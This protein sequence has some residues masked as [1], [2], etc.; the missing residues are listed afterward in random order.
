MSGINHTHEELTESGGLRPNPHSEIAPLGSI[1]RDTDNAKHHDAKQVRLIAASM[2]RFGFL[3]P[4]VV[5][6]NEMIVAG[7]GRYLAAKLLGLKQVPV[8]RARFLTEEDRTAYALADNKLAELSPWK[9]DVLAKQ[10][11]DL[12]AKNYDLGVTGFTLGDIDFSIPGEKTADEIEVVELPDANAKPVS[13]IGD[14]WLAGEHRLFNGDSQRPES[15][16]YAL[17]GDLARLICSDPPYGVKVRHNVS[18]KATAREFVMMSGE[19]T[20]PELI[21]FFRAVF[22]NCA[23]FSHEASIHYHFIDW[24]NLRHML[25]AADGVY[26]EFKQLLV[27]VKR[28][29]AL[30]AFYRSRHELVCVFKSG[31]GRHVNNFKMGET[32]RYRTNVLEHAGCSTFSKTRQRDL[33]DHPSIKPT[34]MIAEL[35]LDCSNS[36]D[37]VLDP[38]CGSGTILLAASKVGRR[39]VGI[40]LD[41][42]YV[43]TALRRLRDATGLVATLAGDGRTFDEIAAE[44]LSSQEA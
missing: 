6:E 21:A 32:G 4:I 26:E 38:F 20:T 1:R 8:V 14:L 34:A 41:P 44:R 24:R 36:G 30:G 16:E 23:R 28:A 19:Q 11:N 12:V 22:R 35:L 9:D 13:R 40:E 3:A 17:G 27:W 18:T 15:F 5:D 31:R 29:G 37:V 25:D 42:L 7:D 43:D 2:E 39:G 10:L 33:D